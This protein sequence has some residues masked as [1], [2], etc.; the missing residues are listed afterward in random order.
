VT[1]TSELGSLFRFRPLFHSG[2]EFVILKGMND[3]VSPG[4]GRSPVSTRDEIDDV[5]LLLSILSAGTLSNVGPTICIARVLNE[6]CAVT[7]AALAAATCCDGVAP[8]LTPRIIGVIEAGS[9]SDHAREAYLKYLEDEHAGDP[10]FAAFVMK[11]FAQPQPYP[12]Q[13]Y[14]REQLVPDAVWYGSKHVCVYRRAAEVDSCIYSVVSADE[15]NRLWSMGLH[16]PDSAPPFAERE[17]RLVERL[18]RAL[19]PLMREVW[20]AGD[21][22]GELISHLPLRLQRTLAHL[23]EG[24]S[25]KQIAQRMGLSQNTVHDYVKQIHRRLG[26]SSRAELLVACLG[27]GGHRYAVPGGKES[28]RDTPV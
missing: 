25:E 6:L 28:V 14:L 17:R 24:L 20:G 2:A 12:P 4:H 10:F 27:R 9:I 11:L 23:L 5:D 8:E 26:V 13:T 16:R 15:P 21:S 1:K 7:G 3:D 18:H 22:F 19:I